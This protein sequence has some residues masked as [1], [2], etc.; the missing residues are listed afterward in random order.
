MRIHFSDRESWRAWL[1]EHHE[2]AREVWLIFYK[3]HTG[4]VT[5]S[6]NAAVEE[7]LCFGWIDSIVKRLDDRRYIQ[8]FTPRTGTGRWS[9][10]NLKR[11]SQLVDA[12]LMTD[13]GRAKLAPGVKA[14]A[15]PVRRNFAMPSIL[16]RALD[17]NAK[18]K[19]HFQEMTPSRQRAYITWIATAKRSETVERRLREALSLLA[20]NEPLGVK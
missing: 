1:S 11:F 5:V 20:R 4:T 10:S 18:A 19:G 12:G 17:G 13:A 3:R 8:K 14:T 2:D 7:A 6:Y 9:A 16:K 15:P